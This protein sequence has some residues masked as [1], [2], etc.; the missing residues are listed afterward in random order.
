MEE[1]NKQ[2]EAVNLFLNNGILVAP[3]VV[4][5]IAENSGAIQKLISEKISAENFFFLNKDISELLTKKEKIEIN[6]QDFERFLAIAERQ[7]NFSGYDKILEAISKDDVKTAGQ[8]PREVI[9]RPA[10][11]VVFSYKEIPKKIDVQDF[12]SFFNERYKAV[13]K[14]LVNRMELTNILSINRIAAKRERESVSL[15]GLVKDKQYT[16]NQNIVLVLEDPTG[17][18]R[19][20]INKTKPEL[21]DAAR[22]VV[23]DE[24]IGVTGTNADKIVFANQI[25]WP[26]IPKE[27]EL[28]KA[29]YEEYAVFLSDLHVGSRFFLGEEFDNF[30]SWINGERG[31]QQQRDMT[32][33]IKYLF[34]VGDLVDGVGIY[35][36]QEKEL[37]ISDIYA[38]YEVCAELLRKIPENITIVIC[39]GNHD[40]MRI[41]E[42]QLEL[43]KDF[44]KALWEMPNVIIVS[45]PAIINI[46][47]KDDFKGFD[48]LM[49]HGYSFDY[50]V[51][52][53]DSIRNNGG[54]N[55]PELIMKFLLKRRHLAP[56]HSSTLYMPDPNQDYL[57]IGK[58]PDFF[59][60]G[61][62]HKCSVSNYRNVTMIC[63]S[64]WQSTTSFQEKMGHV[65][66][67]CRV[68]IV[69]LQTRNIKL[70]RFGD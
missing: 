66:E 16:K 8:Q 22:D 35:P 32:K 17:S 60:T 4:K 39:A 53:V 30:L 54:Y 47:A 42:P 46:A 51:A 63:G 44:A 1:L 62:I 31:T 70:L 37:V 12:V 24:V 40:A 61:H 20:M 48:V 26:D 49:Y 52:E 38:Q 13:E 59:V 27:R 15:I 2:K 7:K 58:V 68:P 36:G 18:V 3:D 65:P 50:Y 11:D 55:K 56:S 6:W 33:K 67:P 23:L 34:I 9:V 57:V 14:M 29:A 21:Y 45:N 19:V 28:K 69:N 41:S 25:T 64:C 10:V 5:Q 43:Y